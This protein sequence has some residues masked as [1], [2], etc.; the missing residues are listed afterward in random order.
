MSIL[1]RPGTRSGRGFARCWTARTQL[2]SYLNASQDQFGLLEALLRI[3][4]II[5]PYFQRPSHAGSPLCTS[6]PIEGFRPVAK[7]FSFT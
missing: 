7:F 5:D 6:F 2:K 4:K 1:H 3:L